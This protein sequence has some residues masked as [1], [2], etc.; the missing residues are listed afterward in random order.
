[1]KLQNIEQ[2]ITRTGVIS[3]ATLAI[4][5]IIACFTGAFDID[6]SIFSRTPIEDIFLFILG[7]LF[8]LVGFCFPVSFLMNIS[9]L[10]S[11][12]KDANRLKKN[13]ADEENN[14]G[15][16]DFRPSLDLSLCVC[17]DSQQ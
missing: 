15:S 10:A 14:L 3:L 1:M 7:V 12:L 2:K 9:K 8:I 17:A 16:G 5:G 13:C 11:G 6:M 4:I